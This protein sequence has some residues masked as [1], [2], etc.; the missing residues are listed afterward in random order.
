MAGFAY[1]TLAPQPVAASTIVV[2]TGGT[3]PVRQFGSVAENVF[4]SAAVVAPAAEQLGVR[5]AELSDAIE[6]DPVPESNTVLVIGRGPDLERAKTVS[7]AAARSL[8]N[9]LNE[10]TNAKSSIFSAPELA[11]NQGS[12]AARVAV[13]LGAAVGFWLA[14]A[15]SIAHYRWKR[16]LLTIRDA[17]RVSH[18]DMVAVVDGRWPS[19]LGFLRPALDWSNTEPNQ[20]RLARLRE[21][22]GDSA[23]VHL[24]MG[25]I[26]SRPRQRVL[27]RHGAELQ[28]GRRLSGAG[29][30]NG[31]DVRIVV[32]DAGTGEHMLATSDLIGNEVSAMAT[33]E[34]KGL[35]WVR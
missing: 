34:R 13:T 35:V 22:A 9:A 19:W 30:N 15:L 1:A 5:R 31:K 24:D 3:I 8:V 2:D 11:R 12:L 29:T 4:S 14:F 32:A 17:L 18:A 26:Q 16:P 25:G 20:F 28:I 23:Y 6:L 27:A 33:K 7:G 21:L 10:Q